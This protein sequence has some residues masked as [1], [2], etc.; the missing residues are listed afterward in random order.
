MFVY[1]KFVYVNERD[2]GG[3][4]EAKMQTNVSLCFSFLHFPPSS[5]CNQSYKTHSVESLKTPAVLCLSLDGC[6][7]FWSDC[8]KKIEEHVDTIGSIELVQI[9]SIRGCFHVNR[10]THLHEPAIH[11]LFLRDDMNEA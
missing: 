9:A 3:N 7:E 4:R 10:H 1:T 6:E 5:L 2:K 8:K 11:P